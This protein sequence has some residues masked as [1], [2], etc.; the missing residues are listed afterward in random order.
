V[1]GLYNYPTPPSVLMSRLGA[2][3]ADDTAA[4][5]ATIMSFINGDYADQL[6]DLHDQITEQYKQ[7]D[8]T[9][10]AIQVLP[11]GP[12]KTQAFKLQQQAVAAVNQQFVAYRQA[13]DKYNDIATQIAAYTMGLYKPAVLSDFGQLETVMTV[14]AIAAIAYAI[15]QLGSIIAAARGQV[16][17]TKG[18]LDQAADL[19]K[20]A[21]G[22]ITA[23]GAAI[24]KIGLAVVGVA[25]AGLLLW[26]LFK[27]M[28]KRGGSAPVA[29]KEETVSPGPAL[30]AGTGV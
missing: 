7:T 9:Y 12:A 2:M 18:Y 27:H 20:N 10:A 24:P 6:N 26:G 30:S 11:D 21:G 16:V 1:N 29:P 17:N 15:S 8:A 19:V 5:Q 3:A 23:T 25:A 22:T 14:V 28:E 13:R 4:Q